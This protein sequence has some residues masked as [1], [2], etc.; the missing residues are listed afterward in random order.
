[1]GRRDRGKGAQ[2]AVGFRLL[3]CSQNVGHF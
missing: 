3:R 1:M 2:R